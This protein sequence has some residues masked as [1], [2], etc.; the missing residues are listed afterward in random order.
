MFL[1]NRVLPCFLP[2]FEANHE[3]E[4]PDAIFSHP[5]GL[6]E[7]VEKLLEGKS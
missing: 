1:L 5:D 3:I 2:C 7:A 6:K 4:N